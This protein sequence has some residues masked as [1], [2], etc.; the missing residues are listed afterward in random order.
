M[1]T[2]KQWQLIVPGV[3]FCLAAGLIWQ[4]DFVGRHLVSAAVGKDTGRHNNPEKNVK[5]VGV[6]R[7]GSVSGGPLITLPGRARAATQAT[8]F[9][10]VSAPLARIHANPGDQ[11]KRGDILLELDDRDYRRQV[12]VME[13]KL[14]SARAGLL[15]METGARPEDVKILAANLSAA[16]ADL[17]LARKQL[18][19]HAILHKTQA[20]TEQAYDRAKTSVQSLEARVTALKEQVARDTKGARQEDI[21][22]ARAGIEELNVR[23]AIA[24]DQLNDTRLTAP[25]DGVVTR[26]IP[27][28]YE[29]VAQGAPVMMLDD[30]S[31]LEIPVDV[32]ETH[33]RQVLRQKKGAGVNSRFA[34]LFLTTG[35]RQYPARL[36]EYSSRADQATGTYEFVFSVSPDPEDLIFPGMTAEIRVTTAPD[37]AP[38]TGVSIPLQ[39][40]MGVA[41]NSAHVFRVD[42]QTRT[43][44]R[45]AVTFEALAGS[46]RVNVMSGLSRQDLVVA[47]GAAF[48]R[49]GEEIQFD[50]PNDQ[51]A[52]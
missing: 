22:T 36:T 21:L 12:Q 40:L 30:I 26:R 5:T 3:L 47:R 44:V 6:V 49:P 50:L 41:G 28:A 15:K 45:Q 8:L 29:M 23:L 51:G 24:R 48:I 25:F 17:A 42:P 27:D 46:D 35:N 33:V 2:K 32:P 4:W 11:V 31:R 13:S 9:F 19:R 20:V 10:R 16:Q 14:K 34:A 52:M 7:P 38:A 43:A 18:E 37:A 1:K 39:S